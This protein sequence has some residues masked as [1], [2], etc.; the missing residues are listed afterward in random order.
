MN[1][2]KEFLKDK[3]PQDKGIFYALII[4]AVLYTII[5]ALLVI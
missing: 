1:K 3:D 2:I 5:L 4:G